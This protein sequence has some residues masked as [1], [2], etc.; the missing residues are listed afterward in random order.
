[1]GRGQADEER[2][3][4]RRED[5]KLAFHYLSSAASAETYL[6]PERKNTNLNHPISDQNWFL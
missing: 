2:G 3:G 6:S 5:A 4:A 1:M